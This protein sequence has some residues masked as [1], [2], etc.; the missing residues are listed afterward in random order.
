MMSSTR[1]VSAVPSRAPTGASRR[2]SWPRFLLPGLLLLTSAWA[3]LFGA[4][5]AATAVTAS[6][7]AAAHGQAQGLTVSTHPDPWF[8][9]SEDGTPVT[10]ITVTAPDGRDLPVTL[11][12]E[13]FTYG[14]HRQ[15]LQVGTFQVPVGNPFPDRVNVVATTADG[16]GDVPIAVTTF[17][18]A[19]FNRTFWWVVGPMLAVNVGVAV[20]ILFLLTPRAAAQKPR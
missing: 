3:G 10:G 8:V 15:G 18:V 14:P 9:Y 6:L 13:A 11:T 19:S 7:E 16:R 17:D 20:T 12:S 5:I 2:R 4:I 1:T